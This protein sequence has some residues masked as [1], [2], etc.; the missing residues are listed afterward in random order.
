[1]IGGQAATS[2]C[3]PGRMV[4]CSTGG[5]F[6]AGMGYAIPCHADCGDC[7]KACSVR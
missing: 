3:D 2:I 5:T 4:G 7:G 1:M 6:A